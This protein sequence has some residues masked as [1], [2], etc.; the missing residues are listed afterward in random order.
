M[1]KP[2]PVTQAQ[3]TRAIRAAM[4]AGLRV[5]G[6][7]PANGMILTSEAD[8]PERPEDRVNRWDDDD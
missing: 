7:D 4:K 2:A 1:T 8:A 6:I 3:I 5:R